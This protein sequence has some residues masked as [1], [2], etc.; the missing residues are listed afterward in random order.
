MVYLNISKYLVKTQLN[1]NIKLPLDLNSSN[2]APH[3]DANK[4]YKSQD[5]FHHTT[6]EI[7]QSSI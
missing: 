1:E 3:S 7:R 4:S 6:P 2:C 5:D